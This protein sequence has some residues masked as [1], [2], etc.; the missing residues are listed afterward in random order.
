MDDQSI[1]PGAGETEERGTGNG[2]L[3]EEWMEVGVV[4]VM[5]GGDSTEIDTQG[6]HR[7]QGMGAA[8]HENRMDTAGGLERDS[9]GEEK[10]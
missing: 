1:G 4:C 2:E 8:R 6:R 9:R 7:M 10:E 5:Y 3:G